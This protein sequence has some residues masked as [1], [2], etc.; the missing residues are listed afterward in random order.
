MTE[1][2]IVLE[3]KATGT[4]S[5]A[6][7]LA[8]VQV[9]AYSGDAMSLP[10]LGLTVIDLAG[11]ELPG[12]VVLLADHVNE[13]RN[14]CGSGTPEIRDGALWITGH[15]AKN[16]PA[17]LLVADLVASGIELQASVGAVVVE[18]THVRAGKT[19]QVNGR[20]ITASTSGLTLVTKSRLR[21]VSVTPCGADDA[22]QVQI[23][24]HRARES[25]RT[26][27]EQNVEEIR[28]AESE[29]VTGIVRACRGKFPSIEEQA[30]S[31]NWTVDKCELEVLRASRPRHIDHNITTNVVNG[32]HILKAAACRLL[33]TQD[34]A[35]KHFGEEITERS[36]QI[37]S[38]PELCR[39]ALIVD[40][41]QPEGN[42]NQIINAA[43]STTS[44]P[45]ALGDI[46]Q[47]VLLDHY[48]R[49][50]ATWKS[51]CK[52][53]DSQTFHPMKVIRGSMLGGVNSVPPGGE[54]THGVLA[55]EYGEVTPTTYGR[56]VGIDRR[57]I[58]N[59]NTGLFDQVAGELGRLAFSGL[60]DQV[61]GA[62]QQ[63]AGFFTEERTNLGG[64]K[65]DATALQA[66]CT[67]MRIQR[68]EGH[69]LAIEPK[70]LLVPPE[71][72]Y[73]AAELLRSVE[74]ARN[75][76]EAD[77]LP[78]GNA[79]SGTLRLIVEPRLSNTRLGGS[80][81]AWYVLGDA[82]AAPMVVAYVGGVRTPTVESFGFNH[83]PNVLA[84]QWRVYFDHGAAVHD[85]RAAY[86]STGDE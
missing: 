55:E 38:L 17:G 73:V 10:G 2:C 14:V 28:A 66:A 75:T 13:V 56:I 34:L 32:E 19:I 64:S 52:E 27:P 33:G 54:L 6:S 42:V 23:L 51:F 35:V 4:P 53:V 61:Y 43:L 20:S 80:T 59:D 63:T 25:E 58:V 65:L 16:T 31:D 22:T 8:R 48:S 44:L 30:I 40:G 37:G 39:A 15:I 9:M 67:A 81:T 69:D 49:S 78:T 79:L 74:V 84:W 7:N 77:R 5:T 3:A 85:W 70:C 68:L 83:N 60:C 41:R 82:T 1:E 47:K 50:P 26:M 29:R 46:L 57:D 62:L 11:M 24:A 45:A 36:R 76:S 18:K 21:E 12:R 86:K 71:L 72:E